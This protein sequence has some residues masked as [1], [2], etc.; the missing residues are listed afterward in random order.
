MYTGD[1]DIGGTFTDG[2]FTNGAE[3]RV[4]KVLTTPYDITE[5]F[6]NCLKEGA[7]QFAVDLKQF[8]QGMKV[9]RLST[10]LGTNLLVQRSGPK[11]GLLVS[12]GQ[13][14]SLYGNSTSEVVGRLIPREM[15]L[16]IEETVDDRGYLVRATEKEET[17]QAVRQLI[18]SGA[19]MIAVSFCNAILNPV[20][21]RRV[22]EL[23]H[24]RYPV[25][26]LRSVPLQLG[27]D[28][29]Q[30][31]SD[32]LR[33]H[34]VMVNAYLHEEMARV[35]YRAEDRIREN[36]Y[37]LPLLIVHAHGG[38]ARVAK[39]VALQTLSSGPAVATRGA[40]MLARLLQLPYVVTA[41]MGGTSLDIALI[42]DGQYDLD[43]EPEVEGIS[44]F[45]PMIRVGS[46]GAGG[47]SI[48]QVVS[49]E[50]KVGPESAGA[51]PGPAAYNKGGIQPT[52]TDANVNLGYINPDY[53]LGGRMRL[54][55][56]KARRAIEQRV[57]KPLGL[58]VE[59]GALAVRSW[60]N[61]TIAHG[62][63]ERIRYQGLNPS[64]FTLFAFGGAGPLHA[65]DVA[66]LMGIERVVAFPYGAV[67]S[68][69]GSSS[70]DV[71]HSYLLSL[72][73]RVDIE[74][75]S[76]K[77]AELRKQ[78]CRDMRGEGFPDDE[79]RFSIDLV[80]D[81]GGNKFRKHFTGPT[82]VSRLP[83]DMVR[84]WADEISRSSQQEP[85]THLILMAECDVSHWTPPFIAEEERSLDAAYKGKRSVFWDEKGSQHSAIFERDSL[86]PG[87]RIE[88][89][90]I[91]EAPD[92]S[93][94]VP[95]AWCSRMDNY[96]NLVFEHRR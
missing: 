57:S 26:Y 30:A 89:P 7:E 13:E 5:C 10:T 62:M 85:A 16:G 81:Q 58:K 32:R 17:L 39:T 52:V 67:F 72:N 71:L 25:H 45:N 92:T 80:V 11:V 48:A 76:L 61:R 64:Q 49:G 79:I 42:I 96:G 2:F 22:R 3:A 43:L 66:A 56:D 74:D 6:L 20:N 86:R 46:L 53:F 31:T 36:G 88:G 14:Q 91:I 21:E 95:P 63:S 27:T 9:L 70:A 69:F 78:A 84:E 93:Y 24:E 23:V 33:T 18:N 73:G 75:L 94:S 77:L 41:D 29:S 4:A 87:D 82:R 8:L 51:V 40:A 12:A 37:M 1:I 47:G 19:R 15:I 60:I 54:D 83:D 34:S 44:L 35:L 90:A 38:S 50:L 55:A 59:A 28:V 68:A 65:C